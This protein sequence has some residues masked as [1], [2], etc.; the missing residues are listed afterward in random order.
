[1]AHWPAKAKWNDED[2]LLRVAGD[3]TVPVEVIALMIYFFIVREDTCS[4]LRSNYQTVLLHTPGE[5]ICVVTVG[6][7]A[8]V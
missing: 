6:F 1:M 8:K 2:Y 4:S 5:Y 3:R 7:K